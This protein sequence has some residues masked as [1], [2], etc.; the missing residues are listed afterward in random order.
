MHWIIENK[1]WLFSGILITIPLT[2]ISWKKR[3]KLK[4]NDGKDVTNSVD[5]N[6]KADIIEN[7]IIE[8]YS[9]R[10]NKVL[11]RINAETYNNLNVKTL[12]RLLNEES[13]EELL[14]AFEG[15]IIPKYKTLDKLCN[16]FGINKNYLDGLEE[17]IFYT[18]N[19]R[20]LSPLDNWSLIEAEKP[21]SVYFI[22]EKSEIRESF[23]VLKISKYKYI[24]L[25]RLYHLSSHVGA[26]GQRQ[27]YE[28]FKLIEKVKNN[29][30][31]YQS[32]I[33]DE[34]IFNDICFGNLYPAYLSKPNII[35]SYWADDLFD[36]NYTDWNKE[37]YINLYGDEFVYVHD[38]IRR[39]YT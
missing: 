2:L 8:N 33:L 21:M 29:K 15:S 9:E 19:N 25:P 13:A 23:I 4:I 39:M 24:V 32:F 7:K 37:K 3:R 18:S 31:H 26:T 5:I 34:N 1:E 30:I 17:Q 10:L 14:K 16:Y 22:M 36:Y 6:I 38:Q 35:T 11:S 12:A 27:I 20:P 28:Y